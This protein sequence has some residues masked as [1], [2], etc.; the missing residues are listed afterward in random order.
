MK[1][2]KSLCFGD[3]SFKYTKN[4]EPEM[5]LIVSTKYG[6]AIERNLFKRRCRAAFKST[7]VDNNMDCAIIVRPK[8]PGVSFRN[9]QESFNSIYDKFSD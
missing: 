8:K 5:G 3:L 2:S 7:M 1:T 9:I 6:N 4:S